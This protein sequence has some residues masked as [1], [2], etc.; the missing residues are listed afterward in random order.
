MKTFLPKKL[1]P[2]NFHKN[3]KN[4]EFLHILHDQLA[5]YHYEGYN[6]IF[7][8]KNRIFVIHEIL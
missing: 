1:R 7:N 4:C 8:E 2:S 5:Y 6:L 3:K